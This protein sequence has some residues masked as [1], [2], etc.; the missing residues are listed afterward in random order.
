MKM[1]P[2]VLFSNSTIL[3]ILKL[4]LTYQEYRIAYMYAIDLANDVSFKIPVKLMDL[5]KISGKSEIFVRRWIEEPTLNVLVMNKSSDS[6]WIQV[7][8]NLQPNDVT[9]I[10]FTALNSNEN[11]THFQ[12]WMKLSMK[13]LIIWGTSLIAVNQFNINQIDTISIYPYNERV[14]Q[15]FVEDYLKE[16]KNGKGSKLTF[17]MQHIPPHSSVGPIYGS[18]NYTFNGPDGVI[19]DLLVKA[20]NVSSVFVS[21]IARVY[22]FFVEWKKSPQKIARG[23]YYRYHKEATT[24]NFIT[25]FNAT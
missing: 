8:R 21:D 23:I 14:T 15:R 9:L 16:S 6:Q 11:K 25:K 13:V 18:D 22:P 2:I 10:V 20:L 12:S 17:F 5:G 24:S 4:I 19:S 7:N 1:D 3:S